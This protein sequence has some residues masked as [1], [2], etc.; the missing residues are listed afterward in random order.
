MKI[1]SN[2]ELIQP[3]NHSIEIKSVDSIKIKKISNFADFLKDGVKL[4]NLKKAVIIEEKVY[5]NY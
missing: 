5:V 4:K 1:I 3:L 2:I